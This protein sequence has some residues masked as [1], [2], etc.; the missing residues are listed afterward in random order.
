MLQS[1]CLLAQTV[2]G[3]LRPSVAKNA[4][5]QDAHVQ[6]KLSLG[7]TQGKNKKWL[8]KTGDPLI[9][10]HLFRIF[11][12]RTQKMCLLKTCDSLIEVAT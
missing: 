10:V 6:S 3:M 7:I 8:L 5:S 1:V 4:F 11:V 2:H 12:Q 9:Q